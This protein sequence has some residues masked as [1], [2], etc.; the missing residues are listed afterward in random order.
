MRNVIFAALAAFIVVFVSSPATADTPRVSYALTMPDPAAHVF[1]ITMRVDGV[2]RPTSVVRMPIWIPGYY[3]DDQY[4]RNVFDFEATD[5]SGRSLTFNRDGQSAYRIDTAGITSFN[6]R[7]ALFADRN[8]D[9]GTQLSEERAL[10]NGA[11]TFMYLQNDDGYPAPGAVTLA[12][13]APSTWR[14]ESGL[15]AM[16]TS[17][18]HFTAPSY[19][20]LVDCPTVISPHLQVRTFGVNDVP[21]HLVVD[22]TGTYDMDALARTAKSIIA[23]EVKMMGHAGYKE[24]WALFL[25]GQGGGME[26]LNSTLSGMAAFGWEQPHDPS[27]GGFRGSPWNGFALVLAHEHFHSWNVKRIRPAVL[28]PFRYDQ[29][30]HTRRL[31]VAEGLT[32]YYTFVHGMR[33]G[34]STPTATWGAFADNIDTEEN[35]PGRKTLSL[36]DLSWNTWWASDDPYVPG[37]DYYDGAAAMAL[38][39]DLKIRHDTNDAHSL[40][41]VLRYLFADWESKALD[42]FRSPG[43]TYTDDALPGIIEKATGDA[44]AGALFHEWWDTTTLPDWNTYLG[45]AGLEL[46]RTMPKPGAATLDADSREI[47][48]SNIVGYQP[49]GARAYGYPVQSPDAVMLTR[50]LPGGAAERA[51]LQQFD[52]LQSLDGI[53]VTQNNLPGILASHHAGDRM[54]A[55]VLRDRRTIVLTVTLGQDH[56]PKYEIRPVGNPTPA[57]QQLLKDYKAGV[58]FGK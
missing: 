49:R 30:V 7:Y 33:S 54:Q 22:G 35:E 45:Y 4:G 8:A 20:V 42:Q 52:V 39:L 5:E 53:G 38:M 2:A 13:D 18:D 9:I 17:A 1:H 10:F 23:S 15:L 29:E 56:H 40:D 3:G 31:D 27:M 6:I 57:Q 50:V 43:G 32:E 46:V 12:I 58:P 26:H 19:D 37:G 28:G 21:Y 51:G 11:E 34:F 41:D 47:G 36:G 55:I 16:Q 44:A 24:Y 14:L 25:A 48:V